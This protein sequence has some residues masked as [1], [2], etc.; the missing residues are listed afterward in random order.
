MQYF[1]S[2]IGCFV[3]DHSIR[4]LTSPRSLLVWPTA[5]ACVAGSVPTLIVSPQR[6][7]APASSSSS[8]IL[9]IPQSLF[10]ASLSSALCHCVHLFLITSL[11]LFHC[12]LHSYPSSLPPRL[13]GWAQEQWT[14][15][16]S[17][18]FGCVRINAVSSA[19]KTTATARCQ[20]VLGWSCHPHTHTPHTH[21]HTPRQACTR[22][23]ACA[24]LHTQ[25]EGSWLI[26][27]RQSK[28]AALRQSVCNPGVCFCSVSK[29]H[30]QWLWTGRYEI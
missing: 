17:F 26:V 14:G 2:L 18:W 13:L 19:V 16:V 23:A 8:L 27:I 7:F 11:H 9:P 10:P 22:R 1:V 30:S 28:S 6:S 4:A 12:C 3:D 29:Y 15:V 5:C 24:Q 25:H 20:S 21:T